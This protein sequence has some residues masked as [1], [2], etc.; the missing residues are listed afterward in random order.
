MREIE[1]E[2]KK[3]TGRWKQKESERKKKKKRKKQL[4][5][6]QVTK[7]CKDNNNE[8]GFPEAY[9]KKTQK[10]KQEERRDNTNKVRRPK[11]RDKRNIPSCCEC[12]CGKLPNVHFHLGIQCQFHDRNVQNDEVLDQ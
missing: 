12:E 8:T 9:H 11:I 5:N 6:G 1:R 10:K 7:S 2:R 3:L 4:N